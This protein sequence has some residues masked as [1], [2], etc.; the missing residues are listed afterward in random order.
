MR[1]M[2]IGVAW[3]LALVLHATE[4]G[5]EPQANFALTAG[6]TG[7]GK[8]SFWEEARA[9]LGVRGDWLFGRACN[10]DFGIGP[11][12]EVLTSFDDVSVGAGMSGLI[13]V[14][15]YLPVVASL[16]AY[17]R[18]GPGAGW[19]PGVTAQFFWG[20]RSFN[21]H[22]WYVM[23]GGL[24]L[25]ARYGLGNTQERA[26]MVGA[27]VDGQVISLPFILVYELVRGSS[28]E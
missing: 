14:H 3:A 16:G 24:T 2:S 17:G 28:A 11:Y 25:Q 26:L 7:R 19:E 21:Y 22:G 18:N 6:V 4:A 20:S 12:G 27:H 5:A 23:A 10:R 1:T 15:S 9:S 8:G 13:P